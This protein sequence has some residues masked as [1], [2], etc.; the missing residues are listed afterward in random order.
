MA[1]GESLE[2]LLAQ[3]DAAKAAGRE[4]GA[5]R[6][7]KGPRIARIEDVHNPTFRPPPKKEDVK[8]LIASDISRHFVGFTRS[9]GGEM[10]AIPSY[11]KPK[12]LSPWT[13]ER[14]NQPERTYK[15]PRGVAPPRFRSQPE[16]FPEP[17]DSLCHPM[18][19]RWLKEHKKARDKHVN[20]IYHALKQVEKSQE[21]LEA[22]RERR[23]L[24]RELLTS[25]ARAPPVMSD[26]AK[27]TL[28]KVK[29]AV[30]ISRAFHKA[31]RIDV[32]ALEEQKDKDRLEKA[33]SSPVL[34]L[35]AP[36]PENQARH[37]RRWAGTDG[38]L[39]SLRESTPWRT[40]DEDREV[41]ARQTKR[42]T[43]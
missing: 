11:M 24:T 36:T 25:D 34:R 22:H 29:H 17:R 12:F 4:A 14:M 19:R 15:C 23:E 32:L 10:G 26:G 6:P 40:Q 39:R 28:K 30:A 1:G 5:I 37:L 38:A 3:C 35:R 7:D 33:K 31:A 43:A 21:Q 13:V 16:L 18:H 9:A 20:P 27:A 8:R 2:T 41:K 42:L